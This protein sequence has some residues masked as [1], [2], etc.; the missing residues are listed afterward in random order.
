MTLKEAFINK[1]IETVA[2]AAEND[3]DG[4]ELG[5]KLDEFLD[6]KIGEKTSENLQRGPVSH[7]FYEILA[8]LWQE[9]PTALAEFLELRAKE[10]RENGVT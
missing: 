5:W 2:T 7:F 6:K 1:M 3:Y 10:I 9:Q 8:G 4:R